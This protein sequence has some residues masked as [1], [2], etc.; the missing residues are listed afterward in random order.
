MRAAQEARAP[1]LF[2]A[3]LNQVDRDGGY[4]GWTPAD[5]V[6]FVRDE[7]EQQS[8]DGPVLIGLDHGGPWA[9]DDHIQRD[10]GRDAAMQATA[11]SIAACVDAGYDLL[12]IDPTHDPD[13]AS[14]T[15]VPVDTIVDRTTDLMQQ[16]EDRRRAADRGPI[17]YEVGTEEAGQEHE[18]E[19]RV[20]TFLRQFDD[21]IDTSELPLPSFIVGDVGTRLASTTFDVGR[22]RRLT[23]ETTRRFGAV[24]K[25]HYTDDVTAL[26]K[27]PLSGMGGANV[28]PGLTTVEAEAL[29]DLEDLE[30]E[31]DRDAGL[32]DVLR[33]AVVESGR[34]R[35]W[36]RTGEKGADF[37]DLP[38]ER[39][40]WLVNTG[41]RYVW[42]RPAVKEA[43]AALYEH[44]APYRD[45]DAY[46]EWRLTT[47][48]LRYMHAFNLV[49]LVDRLMGVLP[50][51]STSAGDGPL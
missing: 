49:G 27:Y 19:E 14:G 29:R 23:E 17:A 51:A 2:A 16:A 50:E 33:S 1:L 21:A 35:K 6:A 18:A 36:L 4:T 9:K 46:V 43:R 44:V 28:G 22:A 31:L 11:R 32:S 26:E 47:A 13:R 25:G 39:Q 3:T 34:W 15:P 48:I 8:L 30:R 42:T 37:S 45:A 40:R 12:H 24:L 41:S 38:D 20:R 7:V 5:F 10:L